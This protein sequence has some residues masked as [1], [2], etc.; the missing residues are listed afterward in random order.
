VLLT[1]SARQIYL[2]KRTQRPAIGASESGHD[3]TSQRKEPRISLAI[4]RPASPLQILRPS[5]PHISILPLWSLALNRGIDMF[6]LE[7]LA[8]RRECLGQ[9]IERGADAGGALEI[10]M[11]Q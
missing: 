9:E 1:S 7:E 8:L 6:P 10:I 2:S 4:R 11:R 3:R 5:E